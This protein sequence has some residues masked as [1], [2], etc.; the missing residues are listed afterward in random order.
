MEQR[1]QEGKVSSPA[2]SSGFVLL[3]TQ[4]AAFPSNEL[5]C[6]GK[7]KRMEEDAWTEIQEEEIDIEE[8]VGI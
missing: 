4:H 8:E 6:H 1:T 5:F 7:K 3:L 2:F